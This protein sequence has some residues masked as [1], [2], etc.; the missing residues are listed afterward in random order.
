MIY[1]IIVHCVIYNM[2][3]SFGIKFEVTKNVSPMCLNLVLLRDIIQTTNVVLRVY[4]MKCRLF[5]YHIMV[6]PVQ[7][8]VN[9]NKT[10]Q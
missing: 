5:Q 9:V 1:F 3:T 7:L 8:R 6:K 4:C 2:Y 10:K